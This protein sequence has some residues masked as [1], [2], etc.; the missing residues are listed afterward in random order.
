[1]TR[2]TLLLATFNRNDLL[3]VCL[4]SVT[5]FNNDLEILVLNDG[6]DDPE[7]KSICDDN[8]VTYV[9]TGRGKPD[10]QHWRVP[11]FAWNIGAKLATSPILI[12]S[13]AEIWHVDNCVD[14]IVS[15]V[16]NNRLAVG[17]PTGRY[18]DGSFI[19]NGDY[20]ALTGNLPTRMCY[21]QAVSKHVFYA[22]GGFDETFTGV[23]GDDNDYRDRLVRYGCAL[24]YRAV[25]CVH[26]Y[27]PPL[28]PTAEFKERKAY[29]CR[30]LDKNRRTGV[31]VVNK[32]IDWGA[33]NAA[34]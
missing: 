15:T 14:T 29:N 24:T 33:Y 34:R 16:E 18:D 19:E 3:G 22:V 28:V 2:A 17:C 30:L 7:T 9:W 6:D 1:M 20:D 5:R 4:P 10:K 21:L 8:G 13:C 11:G 23:T 31:V 32:D 26:M 27:H 12:I 25:R